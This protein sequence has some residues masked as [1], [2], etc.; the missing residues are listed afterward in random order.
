MDRNA[1]R[2]FSQFSRVEQ[3]RRIESVHQARIAT[4]VNSGRF[5]LLLIVRRKELL[6][7]RGFETRVTRSS[8]SI[9]QVN[10]IYHVSISSMQ[11]T[12]FLLRF[13]SLIL[14]ITNASLQF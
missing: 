2:H 4:S 10:T 8:H 13:T 12:K 14:G 9:C 5:V 6:R 3:L 1:S 7:L 11:V